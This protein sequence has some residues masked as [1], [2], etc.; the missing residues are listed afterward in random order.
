[1]TVQ[2]ISI[3]SL[4]RDRDPIN[5]R[6]MTRKIIK[7]LRRSFCRYILPLL[8]VVGLFH[9][10]GAVPPGDFV[11]FG[12]AAGD[13][14]LPENDD[15]STAKIVLS[16]PFPFFGS[17]KTSLWINNNGNVTFDGPIHTGTPFAFPSDREMVA[18]FF[19]DV[20]TCNT[21]ACDGT[22]DA[23]GDSLNDLYYSERFGGGDMAMVSAAVNAAFGGAFS[24]LYAFV[25]TWDHVGYYEAHTDHLNSFQLILTTDGVDSFAIFNYLDNGMNWETG[26]DSG[27]FGG[28]GGEEASAGYDAGN[29]KTFYTIPGSNEA[30]IKDILEAGSNMGVPGQWVFQ[31]NDG[32]S[33]PA[34]PAG[35]AASAAGGGCFIATA[36]YGSYF[37]PHVKVLRDFRDEWLLK[38]MRLEVGGLRLTIPNVPGKAFVDFYYRTSPPIA[39]FI[40][41]HDM[42]RAAVRV[43]LTPFVY[44][45]YYP[46]FTVLI[47]SMVMVPILYRRLRNR[48]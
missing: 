38:D 14:R 27:G 21:V 16:V 40:R 2:S 13:L 3:M 10:A 26:D 37:D 45:L 32:A 6:T 44:G 47:M 48:I 36:A 7:I 12:T 34:P 23:E 30:G 46:G 35:G 8:M 17:D 24:A 33:P 41:E 39:D 29:G 18:P 1:M 15:S 22:G 11:P 31:I 28:F 25:V 5:A 4:Y 43:A 9:D 19:A 20:D 42:L